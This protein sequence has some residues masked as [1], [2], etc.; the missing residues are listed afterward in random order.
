MQWPHSHFDPRDIEAGKRRQL[1][2]SQLL[3]QPGW[4]VMRQWLLEQAEAAK[5]KALHATTAE[6]TSEYF[7]VMAA[8]EEAV[9]W[10][11]KELQRTKA[12]EAPAH[13]P[14]PRK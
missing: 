1:E 6:Q 2:V 7:R 4:A 3:Q 5:R 12:F 13:Q 9:S 10:P 11:E 14:M 8:F